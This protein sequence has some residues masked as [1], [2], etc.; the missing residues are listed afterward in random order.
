MNAKRRARHVIRTKQ[1]QRR[2]LGRSKSAVIEF[3]CSTASN[4][5]HEE[6]THHH[7]EFPI[8]ISNVTASTRFHKFTHSSIPSLLYKSKTDVKQHN[9]QPVVIKLIQ[10]VTNQQCL[11]SNGL[12]LLDLRLI[13]G[14]VLR[15]GSMVCNC[16]EPRRAHGTP[17]CALNERTDSG[18]TGLSNVGDMLVV[19][20]VSLLAAPIYRD[21]QCLQLLN[22]TSGQTE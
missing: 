9:K 1:Q 21:V 10:K 22:Q 17:C 16:L 5:G 12:T 4:A 6:I 19:N 15:L 13:C 11:T 18:V 3:A 14:A 2:Q 7:I 20:F 8:K